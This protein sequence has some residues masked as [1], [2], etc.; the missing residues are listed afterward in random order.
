M[1]SSR[2]S[3]SSTRTSRRNRKAC[4]QAARRRLPPPRRAL[5]PLSRPSHPVHPTSTRESSG[6]AAIEDELGSTAPQHELLPLLPPPRRPLLLW[7]RHRRLLPPRRPLLLWGA[8]RNADES[9]TCDRESGARDASPR[10]AWHKAQ[11]SGLPS[12]GA[13]ARQKGRGS[14]DRPRKA[15]LPFERLP[16]APRKPTPEPGGDHA[17]LAWEPVAAW[18]ACVAHPR[19]TIACVQG[20]VW[21]FLAALVLATGSA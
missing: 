16:R 17:R 6:V 4:K 1:S 19:D 10:R 12:H 7:T 13:K 14:R 18:A 9:R 20:G 15:G 5:A 8:R 21:G 11:A 3:P 2:R